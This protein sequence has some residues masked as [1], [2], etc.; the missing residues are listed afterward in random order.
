VARAALSYM[1][2]QGEN[3]V[4]CPMGMA[5]ASIPALQHD[6]GL[7]DEWAP[8]VL[9]AAYD[10]RAVYAKKKNAITVGMAMT[11][12]QGGSDLSATITTGRPATSRRGSGAT[13]LLTGHKWFFS[14]PMSDIF[15]TLAQTEKG[16]SCFI[17]TG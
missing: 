11:E 1:W 17:A 2:N 12:K 9:N 7:Y 10:D 14:V 8:L 5:F 3:G 13:Y 4:C 15:L 6:K 16:L